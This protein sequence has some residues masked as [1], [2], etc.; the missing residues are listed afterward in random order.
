MP[1]LGI[2]HTLRLV[3]CRSLGPIHSDTRANSPPSRVSPIGAET[4]PLDRE[5]GFEREQFSRLSGTC[6]SRL[7]QLGLAIRQPQWL[8]HV[9][10]RSADRRSPTAPDRVPP[11]GASESL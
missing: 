9:P 8:A 3:F 4:H 1:D 2:R 7:W 6:S 11:I 5:K 10:V